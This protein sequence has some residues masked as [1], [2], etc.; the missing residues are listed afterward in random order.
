MKLNWNHHPSHGFRF[1]W[2]D[3]LAIVVCAIATYFGLKTI[4]SLAWLFPFVL[5]HFFLFCNVFRIRRLPELVWAGGFLMLATGCLVADISVLHAMWLVLPLTMGVLIY[6]VRQ[7]HYHGVGTLGP[8]VETSLAEAKLT[9][10][11]R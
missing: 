9:G 1:S 7:P 3:A 4:G 8:E 2:T 6:A 10:G 5:G 11:R